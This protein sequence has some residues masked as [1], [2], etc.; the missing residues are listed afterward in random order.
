MRTTTNEGMA[1]IRRLAGAVAVAALLLA[2]VARADEA[3]QLQALLC[4]DYVDGK[5]VEPTI[6]FAPDS[7][8]IQVVARQPSRRQS[9]TITFVY[10]AEDVGAAAPPNTKIDQL[11]RTLL[12]VPLPMTW[13]TESSLSRPNKG[14]PVGRYRVDI[15]MDGKLVKSLPFTVEAKK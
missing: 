10:V 2:P 5:I 8:K 13:T 15:L 4:R 12:G 6:R 14:W 1:A 7:P 3:P 11:T 9:S